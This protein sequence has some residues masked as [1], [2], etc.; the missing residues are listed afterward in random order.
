MACVLDAVERERSDISISEIAE[1]LGI[2]EDATRKNLERGLK[3]LGR[4]A[5]EA[6]LLPTDQVLVLG[7]DAVLVDED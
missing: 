1:I 7:D 3:R 4:A 5:R 2:S 6:G